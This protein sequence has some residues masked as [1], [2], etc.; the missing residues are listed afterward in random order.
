MKN[1]HVGSKNGFIS[2]YCCLFS[3]ASVINLM[4]HFIVSCV[5]CGIVK[6]YSSKGRY[7]IQN[8]TFKEYND[9]L[10]KALTLAAVVSIVV[11]IVNELKEY[12]KRNEYISSFCSKLFGYK[13]KFDS[14]VKNVLFILSI[15]LVIIGFFLLKAGENLEG[16]KNLNNLVIA[17]FLINILLSFFICEIIIYFIKLD[18]K[19]IKVEK[20]ILGLTRKNFE[21]NFVSNREEIKSLTDVIKLSEDINSA[22]NSILILLDIFSNY[23]YFNKIKIFDCL[24]QYIWEMLFEYCEDN[25]CQEY[26]THV[27]FIINNFLEKDTSENNVL[28]TFFLLSNY[29]IYSKPSEFHLLSQ[30][31]KDK[32]FELFPYITIIYSDKLNNLNDLKKF[33]KDLLIDNNLELVSKKYYNILYNS[34]QYLF[35]FKFANNEINSESY[36]IFKKLK[37]ESLYQLY[38][39]D[40]L[41]C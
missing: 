13:Y 27:F 39:Y 31:S 24:T 19:K 41:I 21:I 35:D 22:K 37:D 2:H 17:I 18:Y 34:L 28:L 3:R 29:F 6:S 26:K 23:N 38:I 14:I 30:R 11:F 25:K 12:S 15:L 40:Y 7:F 1:I 36:F 33:Y 8:Q 20:S 16:Y 32:F 9:S 5:S 10:S 4:L